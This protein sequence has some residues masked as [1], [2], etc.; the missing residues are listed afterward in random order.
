MDTNPV[1]QNQSKIRY[2]AQ[3]PQRTREFLPDV[4]AIRVRSIINSGK[5]WVNGTD[6]TYY[7]FK[8]GDAV[9]I[10][11]HGDPSDIAQVDA[12]FAQWFSLG[13][14]ISFRAVLHPED[15]IIRIGFD[16]ADG[17]WSF[18]GRDVLNIRD[19]VQRT[20]NFGWSL[21]TPYGHDT[22]LHEIGHTLGLEHEHQNPFAG[23]VW[24]EG[25]V[26]AYFRGDPNNWTDEQI[27]HNILNKIAISLVKGTKWDPDSV[28]E[29]EFEG[30]LI[31]EPALYRNG[32]K[33]SGG[34]SVEDQSWVRRSYPVIGPQLPQLQTALSQKLALS[35]GE[36][37]VFEFK[38]TRSRTYKIGTFGNADTVVVLFEVTP[39]GNVEIAGDDDSGEDRNAQIS[40]RLA[41]GRTYQV[42]VRLYH[43]DSVED[44][45]LM[46]W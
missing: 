4:S 30:G 26:R 43:A 32:L 45:S 24:N 22:A 28:M 27:S 16:Q 13:L 9:P 6:L 31:V 46:A 3:P 40:M 23:I 14:G 41:A 1:S 12:A 7:R 29:Y 18:V 2:C 8:Q 37:R 42:G 44:I 11:W 5:K 36:T 21:T 19:P 20:M 25:A 38:P 10:S 34:L 15:A 33:P 17:S 35:A 39:Q